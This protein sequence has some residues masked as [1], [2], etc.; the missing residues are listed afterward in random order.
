MFWWYRHLPSIQ[1]LSGT[2]TVITDAVQFQ[3]TIT[4][5]SDFP[6]SAS[7]QN[8]WLYII[9]ANVTDND[10]SKTNTGLSFLAWDDIIW[11]GSTW[12]TV[13][14]V[15]PT[16]QQVTAAWA[17]TTSTITTAWLILATWGAVK[18]STSAGNTLL[19]QAYDVDG[20]AYTTFGTLTANNTP[21]FD[22]SDSVTKWGQYIYRWWGTDVPVA[23]GWTGASDAA[24]ARTNLGLVIGTDVQAYDAELAAIAWLVSAADKLPYFT[25]SGTAALADFTS[26][27]RS[28]A[29]DVDAAA[30]RTTL[31]LWTLA[32]QSGT[33]SGT[34]SWTNTGDQTITLTWDVTWSGTWSFAATI[35]NDA[36]TYAKLQNAAAGNVV[37]ARA[38]ATSWD[39][40]EVALAASRLLGRWSTGD[41]A[42]ITL[43]SGLSMSGTTLSATGA[44]GDVVWPASAT[45]NAIV[46]Y[47]TTTGK[48]VQ[49]S[50][51]TID[52][53]GV[54]YGVTD[55]S[56]ANGAGT[57]AFFA[58]TVQVDML[59]AQ[60]IAAWWPIFDSAGLVPLLWFYEGIS[61]VNWVSV[62][63][64]ATWVDPKIYADGDWTD[65]NISLDIV[66]QW[67]WV[68]K[69]NWVEVPTISSTN[70]I[71][72]KTV[73]LTNNTLSWTKAQF[74]TA[75]SD[76]N[77]LY[78]W[79]ITQYTDEMAQDAVGG[80]LVDGNTVNFTYA[81]ATPSI[82]AEVITQMSLTSDAS[83]IKLSGDSA[84]PGNSKYYGTDGAW[85]KWWY[86][87]PSGLWDV[88][89]A[90]SLT[91]NA[92]VRG[93]GG[94]K[95]VQTSGVTIS[96]T[97][98]LSWATQLNVDNL[99]L[100]GNTI[101]ST[102][103]NWNINLTPNGAGINVLANAQVTWLTASQI[104]AT[105]GSKNLQSL[106]TATYPSLTEL[107]YVKW[108]SS[109]IQT[110]LWTKAASW[111]NTD[112]T[113]VYL[114]NTGLKIK[115]TNA[116]HWLIIAPWSDL[117]AD[118]TLTITTWDA[119]RTLDISA[120]S[121]TIWS[122]AASFLDD[123]DEAAFKATVNLEIWVDVQAYDADLWALAGVS[124][125]GMLARTGAG[126]AAA[127][128]ITGT[129]NEISVANG[130]GVSGNPTLSLPA[131]ID[132]GGKTSFEIPNG[133]GGTTVDAAWEVCIDTTSKTL[134]FYDGSNEVV[135]TPIMSKSV[136]VE[137][138]TAA[139]D[140]SLFYTDDAI[141]IT[142]I[143]FVIVWSTSVTTTIRH[144]TD[145]SNTGNEVVTG[146]TTANSTT[147]GNVVTS[148]NDPTVPADSFVWLET[149][150]LSGT[151]TSLNVTIFYRQDA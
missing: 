122:F 81:D 64:T 103:V 74:D 131:T 45:D 150:A 143:V 144:H 121:V 139:E 56:T 75:C 130:D 41:I 69:A 20:W 108:V 7:V 89:A 116:S 115:D 97:D 27:W 123:A 58:D 133:A 54:I 141:T 36:V 98:V 126:T 23:D 94:A 83:G 38:A 62:G 16:L 65:I 26:F 93:D 87:L 73:N 78:V 148:F 95:W 31:G 86:S 33:F 114:N 44:L 119:A 8:G 59:S 99:R 84:T 82:T 52:D 60:G 35:A 106:D 151:P 47:D 100:D 66:T 107:S 61:A 6:T 51:I 24:T 91:D 10:P 138:P 149:T 104:V 53:T 49:N 21:T 34:S 90:A 50:A 14:S 5:A 2:S 3:W 13:W 147:T 57:I 125:N 110:Q 127:R 11:N 85:T 92:I 18:T 30:A 77:F 79:D 124:S 118:R 137:S 142:K 63:N 135:L 129:S 140:I 42:A 17:S 25:W 112:I 102:D 71:T 28:L 70:T 120:A 109:A 68:L 101:S 88:T 1:I 134:N 72:N 146:W 76:G 19:L 132:L 12:V 43:W 80:I 40:S 32:T 105:D 39:Y 46:R 15:T 128:T 9:G 22:L 29:D 145:R 96:D 4:V 55:I 67:T 113:S 37:L 117:T 111:A 136:T 48:L